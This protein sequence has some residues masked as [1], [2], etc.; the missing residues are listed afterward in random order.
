MLKFSSWVKNQK[1]IPINNVQSAEIKA[2]IA[3]GK[4]L[5]LILSVRVL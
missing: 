3:T 5:F 2:L 1:S 4:K